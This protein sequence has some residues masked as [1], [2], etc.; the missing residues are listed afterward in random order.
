MFDPS[1]LNNIRTAGVFIL[2]ENSFAFMIGPN[3]TRD[4]LG[5]VRFGGHVENNENIFECISREVQE[6]AST[7]VEIIDSPVTYYK[8]KWDSEECIEL[9]D[10]LPFTRNPIIVVGDEEHSTVV[11]LSYAKGK[12]QP[13]CETHGIIYLNRAD[14][15]KI[16]NT[17][18]LLDDFIQAGGRIVEQKELDLNME[19]VAGPHLKFL[20]YLMSRNYQLIM[21]FFNRDI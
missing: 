18:I 15:T 5:I 21:S 7:E 9:D 3:K 2:H 10:S 11:F 17:K 6:E 20:D 16:C 19:M 13:S 8:R 1:I 4:K 12:L 14:I